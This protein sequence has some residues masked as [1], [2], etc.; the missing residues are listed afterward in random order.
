[1]KQRNRAAFVAHNSAGISERLDVL[2][3][4]HAHKNEIGSIVD[5]IC[6]IT[7]QLADQQLKLTDTK[8][9][10]FDCRR[11][12]HPYSGQDRKTLHPQTRRN[13]ERETEHR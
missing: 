4:I 2:F 10:K 8:A 11:R 13:N 12:K 6:Q 3:S 7:E 5:C 1:M 9:Q